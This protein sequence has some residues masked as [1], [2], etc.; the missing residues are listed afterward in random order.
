MQ[1]LTKPITH[2]RPGSAIV[3]NTQRMTDTKHF[4]GHGKLLLTGE[5]FVLDGAR[6]LSIPTRFGQHLRVKTLSGNSNTLYWIALNNLRQPWL[7]LA[8]D[9]ND[10]SC[11]NATSPEARSLSKILTQVRMLNPDFLMTDEDIAVETFLEFPNDWG[12]G[13]SSTLLY[14]ISQWAAIDGY[15]L[16]QNTM[17]GSGYDVINAGS[18]TPVLYQLK[19]GTPHYDQVFFMP[20]FYENIFF[21]H[22]GQK[23]LS[24]AG[25]K[26]Y[27]ENASRIQDCIVWL[28]RITESMLQCQ[29]LKKMDQL[30]DEHEQIIAEELK[31]PKVKDTLLPDYWGAVKS[32]GAWGGDFVML[33]N[34]RS[35]EELISYLHSRDLHVIHRFDKMIFKPG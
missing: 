12:L 8:F 1:T 20:P 16:L 35:E 6:A 14:C 19:D 7:N 10:F 33:T 32:L 25:I 5:Y 31:L 22:T 13:S 2:I 21:V 26:Y 34:D 29:S 11:I 24:T 27:R 3:T 9:K 18:N 28:D 15:T 23:Q 4:Y 17:G 30:I